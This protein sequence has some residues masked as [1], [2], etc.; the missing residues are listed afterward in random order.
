[1]ARGELRVVGE[2]G[3]GADEDRAAA[4]ALLVH[5]GTGASGP[6]I[7]WLVPSAA[8][9]R[10]SR[11]VASFHVTQGRPVRDA[12]QPGAVEGRRLR[13]EQPALGGDALRS[14]SQAAPPAA[15]AFGSLT[16][17]TTRVTP[18]AASAREHGPV[19]PVWWHGSSVT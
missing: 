3:P 17:Y 19:R 4:G 13:L 15:G 6:V 10:P 2:G 14:A 8:A 18:A 5:V 11:V 16:A 9:L 7:H 1:M 12:V